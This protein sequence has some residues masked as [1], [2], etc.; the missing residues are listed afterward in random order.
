MPQTDG[1]PEIVL[2]RWPSRPLLSYVARVTVFLWIG[3]H[4]L[5]GMASGALGQGFGSAASASPLLVVVVAGL[6]MLELKISHQRVLWANLGFSRR[7]LFCFVLALSAVLEL[8]SAT[9]LALTG[10]ALGS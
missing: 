6:F 8:V 4:L 10:A 7:A 1:R 5:V 2:R 3:C 9:F